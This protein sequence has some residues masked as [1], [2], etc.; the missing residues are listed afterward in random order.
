MKKSDLKNKMQFPGMV[1]KTNRDLNLSFRDT[2]DTVDNYNLQGNKYPN[3]I[4]ISKGTELLILSYEDNNFFH[5]LM[6]KR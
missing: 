6:D 5:I 2:M 4:K 1:L 3:R